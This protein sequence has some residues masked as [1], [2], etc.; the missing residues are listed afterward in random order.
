MSITLEVSIDAE[1]FA[2]GRT[3]REMP[4][5]TGE[6]ERLATH[7]REWV[8]PFLWVENCDFSA[9]ESTMRRDPTVEAV[10]LIDADSATGVFSVHWSSDVQ[11]LIDAIVDQ[12]GIMLKAA[13]RDRAW[14]LK[15]RFI[16]EPQL[17]EFKSYFD[18]RGAPFE[19]R[20]LHRNPK[21]KQL[22]FDLTPAQYEVLVT[23]LERGYFEVP[24]RTQISELADELGIST[25]SVS[26]RLR[27]ATAALVESTLTARST[28][29]RPG[30][31]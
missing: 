7:S 10:D 8:M 5:A 1:N 23:G 27:R 25:N 31:R 15:L 6:I 21:L 19:I 13:F 17:R 26:Q 18:Q 30:E 22:E 16:D 2:L 11:E 28:R 24:R 14:H 4:H 9:F 20:R 3:L 12:H 29:D